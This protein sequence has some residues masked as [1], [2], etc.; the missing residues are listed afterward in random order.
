MTIGEV[1]GA[2]IAARVSAS[3][4]DSHFG[5]CDATLLG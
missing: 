5:A 3:A 2:R 4:Q 1:L